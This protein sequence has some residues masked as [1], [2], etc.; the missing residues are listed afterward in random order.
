MFILE[1][2][3]EKIGA[4]LNQLILAK[5]PNVRRFC[6]A[7]LKLGNLDWHDD[8]VIAKMQ[9]RMSQIIKGNKA[10]Q[11]YDL[12]I[13]CE[14]LDVS[15]EEI[16]SAGK[17]FVPISGHVTNYE[18]AFSKDK[19]MWDKYI[20]RE[21]KLILNP[22]EYNKTVIDYAL[23]FKNYDFLKYLTDN[24]YI[25]FVDDSQHDYHERAFGFSAG[26]S[27]KRRERGFQDILDVTLKYRSEELGLRQ[28][29]IALAMENN[30]FCML[31]CLHAREVPTLYQACIYM[32]P[33][34]KCKD[35]YNENVIK[36]IAG[37]NSDMVF[38]Y[39][40]EDFPIKDRFEREHWF[41][42]PYIGKLL[43]LLITNKNKYAEAVLRRTIDH[44]KRIYSKLIEMVNEAFDLSE[45][46]FNQSDNY[47]VPVETVVND[48]MHYYTFD[49]EDGFLSYMFARD[50]NDCTKFCANVIY[51]ELKSDDL[52]IDTLIE[53][54]NKLYEAVK[55]IQPDTSKY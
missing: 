41:I 29:M 23:E 35:Y 2:N 44:N 39:F 12:P 45:D 22:D 43:E 6:I 11:I 49:D 5:Y 55:N 27:I 26:T 21:D 33:Q 38:R 13:F 31:E 10:I 14:L 16:V 18:I 19:A 46:Y 53:E 7:Y 34:T 3:N 36:E 28:K 54:L 52:L 48:A 9:N 24:G 17:H 4:Y 32:N 30:D 47:K 25:W 40:S 51:V 37:S 15:C 20:N 1:K 42:Y 8:A 50:K